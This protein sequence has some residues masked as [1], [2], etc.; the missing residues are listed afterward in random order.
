[1]SK[2]PFE[3]YPEHGFNGID[4][5]SSQSDVNDA[6]LPGSRR[7]QVSKRR[8]EH[9]ISKTHNISSPL[10]NHRCL[11]HPDYDGTI[12]HGPFVNRFHPREAF[13]CTDYQRF[14]HKKHNSLVPFHPSG[15]QT[16]PVQG[17]STLISHLDAHP[18]K[19]YPRVS[20][21]PHALP[22]LYEESG[23]RCSNPSAPTCKILPLLI[24]GFILLTESFSH[25]S[26]NSFPLGHLM[27]AGDHK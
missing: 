1:M 9:S 26:C 18:N 3:D 4:G 2:L 8:S 27:C 20:L 22:T 5:S 7:L 24:C 10:R 25:S 19:T 13:P 17:I 15:S 16:L 23:I 11:F 12:G 14:E 21:S 6:L